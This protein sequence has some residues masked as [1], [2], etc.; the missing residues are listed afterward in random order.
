MS[1]LKISFHKSD[2]F[3]FSEAMNK[4][5]AYKR[6]FICPIVKLPVRYLGIPVDEVRIKNT[7]WKSVEN[8]CSC[9]KGK[10]LGIGGRSMHTDMLD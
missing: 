1:G 5:D 3:L 6:I 4:A 8:K 2:L 10:M 7:E 9:W